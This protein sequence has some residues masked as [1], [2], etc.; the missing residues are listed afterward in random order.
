MNG[1]V[2][3]GYITLKN[4]AHALAEIQYAGTDAHDAV[5]K[6]R[7][8]GYD[9]RFTV[10]EY[11]QSAATCWEL[12]D[13]TH[14][15][16]RGMKP[17]HIW[18]EQ[19]KTSRMIQIEPGKL[20]PVPFARSYKV[21]DL[22]YL[23]SGPLFVQ[24][25]HWFDPPFN[26]VVFM[27]KVE[28]LDCLLLNYRRTVRRKARAGAQRVGRP[29]D[30][31]AVQEAILEIDGRGKWNARRDSVKALWQLLGR[32]PYSLDVSESTVSRALKALVKA[33]HDRLQ[34]PPKKTRARP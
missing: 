15:R 33:D 10:E 7:A 9:V 22:S 12:I 28:D 16:K 34:R 17:V 6:V 24:F 5:I 4:A 3:E 11:E 30:S 19:P 29:S 18:V 26:H 13:R 21:G 14:D 31:P 20:A 2:P 1:I 25:S 32:P 27:L 8:A 23:R